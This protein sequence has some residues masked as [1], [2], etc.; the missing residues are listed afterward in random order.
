MAADDL[1]VFQGEESVWLSEDGQALLPVPVPEGDVS[2]L[3]PVP[4]RAAVLAEIGGAP[5][6]LRRCGGRD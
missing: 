5:H 1:L 6:L 2:L 3:A 4:D